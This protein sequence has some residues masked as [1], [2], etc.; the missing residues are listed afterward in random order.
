MWSLCYE[1][2][3]SATENTHADRARMKQETHGWLIEVG[4]TFSHFPNIPVDVFC[5]ILASKNDLAELGR[6]G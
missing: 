3:L 2:I 4:V 1:M 5:L 6:P